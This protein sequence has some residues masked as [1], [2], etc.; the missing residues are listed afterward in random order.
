MNKTPIFVFLTEEYVVPEPVEKERI[1]LE[2][3]FLEYA[4]AWILFKLSCGPTPF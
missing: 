2:L 1:F 3:I 4:Q